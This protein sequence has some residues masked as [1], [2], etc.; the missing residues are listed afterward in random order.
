M[1]AEVKIEK[2]R[3]LEILGKT[4]ALMIP[5]ITRTYKTR[6]AGVCSSAISNNAHKLKESGLLKSIALPNTNR[7]YW[8]TTEVFDRVLEIVTQEPLQLAQIREI[9]RNRYGQI[10]EFESFHR[11][12]IVLREAGI[13]NLEKNIWT[14]AATEQ[15]ECA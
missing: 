8:V 6:Y 12:F 9:Y 11:L 2:N 1:K 15:E 4:P 7:V 13:L 5:Q 14:C 10:P 3:I